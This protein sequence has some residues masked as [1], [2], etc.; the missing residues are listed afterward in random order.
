MRVTLISLCLLTVAGCGPLMRPMVDRLDDQTQ[1][2]VD[3]TWDNMF[4]PV[5]RLDRTLLLDVILV[6]QLHQYGVDRL[7][8]VSE[9]YVGDGLVVMEVSFDRAVPEAD[10]FVVAYVDGDGYEI[11]RE[12]YTRE[13]IEDRIAF[14]FAPPVDTED[15]PPE[16][17]ERHEALELE[18]EARRAEISAILSPMS[19]DES[20]PE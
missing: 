13:D 11:R 12:S 2:R 7:H 18:R 14:L 8:M 4:S 5:D 1:A 15:W 6:G 3:D 9:K 20:E 16:E 17:R 10:E 19:A